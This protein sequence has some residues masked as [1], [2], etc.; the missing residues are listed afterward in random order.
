MLDA[1]GAEAV[2]DGV[3][4]EVDDVDGRG[5]VVVVVLVD[6]VV[7]GVVDE[8]VDEVVVDDEVV[9]VDDSW[10]TAALAGTRNTL[11]SAPATSARAGSMTVYRPDGSRC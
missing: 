5:A 3:D 8:V 11:T 7:V 4:G 6:D 10:A 2:L 9:V 1:G